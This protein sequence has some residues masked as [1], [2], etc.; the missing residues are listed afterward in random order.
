MFHTRREML[1]WLV[2]SGLCLSAADLAWA[3]AKLLPSTGGEVPDL[4]IFDAWMR[5]FL[6]I[7][8]VPGGQLAI[9]RG[10]TLI[11][12][13]GFGYAD[14]DQEIAVEPAS[15]F[16]IA[17]VSKPITAVAILQL[18]E[19]GKLKL[20]DTI[21]NLLK[22]EPLLEPEKKADE[23]WPKITVAMCLAHTAGW[24]RD[25]SYDP[26][27]QQVM[28][29]KSLGV[30]LPIGTAEIIRYMRGA[31]LDSAPGE[32]Y[33]YSNFGYCLLG[34]VI[35]KLTGK[36]YEAYV[37]EEVFAPVGITAPQIGKSLVDEQAAGEVKYFAYGDPQVM[38]LV[39]PHAGDE[40]AKVAI[41]YGGWPQEVLDSHG[42]WVASAQDLVRWG[43]AL[44]KAP[45]VASKQL[46]SA[47]SVR[48]MFSPQSTVKPGD[49]QG[50]G[51]ISYGYGW[52]LGR[53]DDDDAKRII[54]HGGALPCTAASLLKLHD[55]LTI[56]VLFNLGQ[57]KDGN[58]LGR[59]LDAQLV[60]LTR[61]IEHWPQ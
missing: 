11:Y 59:G 30:K 28:I 43:A 57:D 16:R 21:D 29:A 36:T 40:T 46:L 23:R 19:R 47:D 20:D 1:G 14:R 41:S 61:S 26:M 49:N 22:I 13:R 9:A 48:D 18:V 53:E 38:P 8:R 34:R 42:G 5:Y 60:K 27:F 56:A 33:A 25:K 7:N 55:G 35:E 3:E 2:S 10:N 32:R 24:D 6:L 44:D 45:T 39:G 37:R 12:S 31:P 52:V 17:S 51:K 50:R 58:F 54:G 4:Q 15:L